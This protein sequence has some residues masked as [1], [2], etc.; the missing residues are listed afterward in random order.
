[1]RSRPTAGQATLEYIAAVALLAA[2]FLVAAPAVGAPDLG[3]KVFAAVKHGICLAGGDICTS[4]DA[5]RAGLAPCQLKSDTT[6]GEGFVT[7]FSVELGGKWLLT[8]T[9]QSDGTVAV[10]RTAAGSAGITGGVGAEFALG[11]V[12]GSAAA[13]LRVQGARGWTFPDQTAANRFLEHSARNAFDEERWP[14]AWESGELASEVSAMGGAS[15]GVDG[16]KERLDLISASVAGQAAIGAR[17]TRDGLVT[18]YTRIALDGP[19][20][21][22]PLIIAPVG[23]GR[24][25]WI[26]EYSH[27]R[28]GPRELAFRTAKPGDHGN[29]VTETV[30]RL[31]LRDPANLRIARPFLASQEPWSALGGGAKQA[32]LDRITT[33]GVVERTVT[34]I[35][36]D[37]KG[38]ALSLSGG[39]K[40]GI[41]GKKIAVHKRLVRA[42][43]Q[44]GALAGARLDCVVR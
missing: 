18:T 8:V 16:A 9:P 37:S 25:E 34:A 26:A 5:A 38:A 15:L 4:G 13:R 7:A 40:F 14:P 12:G 39:W 42:T 3:G 1:V 36:D 44:R 29:S 20:L 41:G 35:D 22:V 31:D 11:Q 23:V 17:R 33:H 2:V 32:V 43:V 10:V 19:E 6:G 28:G 27:D 21:A 30:A 24:T